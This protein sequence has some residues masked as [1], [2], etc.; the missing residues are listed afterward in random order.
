MSLKN[1]T[2]AVFYGV[3]LAILILLVMFT[4]S[5]LFSHQEV[6]LRALGGIAPPDVQTLVASGSGWFFLIVVAFFSSR[7]LLRSIFG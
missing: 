5:F 1:F 3:I 7:K 6:T 4:L 2:K